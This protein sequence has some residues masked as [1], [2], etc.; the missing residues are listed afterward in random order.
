MRTKNLPMCVSVAVLA[1]VAWGCSSDDS[2]RP[3]YEAPPIWLTGKVVDSSSGAELEGVDVQR[4]W[5]GQGGDEEYVSEEQTAADGSFRV[6]HGF[7][8]GTRKWRFRLNGYLDHEVAIP[9]DAVQIGD[10]AYEVTVEMQ[11]P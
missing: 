2:E 8:H 7:D 9:D 4:H 1:L 11:T 10:E 6:L 5:I 3:I